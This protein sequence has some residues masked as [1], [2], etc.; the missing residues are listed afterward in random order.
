LLIAGD[1]NG[2]A[3]GSI[4]LDD[5]VSF[6]Y[7]EGK[8]VER[9]FTFDKGV[10]KCVKG[11]EL[12]KEVPAFLDNCIVSNLDIYR[13]KPDGTSDVKHIS[14]LNLKLRDEWKWVEPTT[15]N[16]LSLNGYKSWKVI[17]LGVSVT[18]VVAISVVIAIVLKKRRK[19]EEKG[20]TEPLKDS[21]DRPYT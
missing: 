18:M 19:C 3:E 15:S 16:E 14:G 10:L 8:F 9:N 20:I 6:S 12:E 2:H 4:Y 17:V 13:V 1:G 21:T 5:G 7:E 11:S